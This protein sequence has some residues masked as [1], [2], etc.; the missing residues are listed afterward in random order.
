MSHT[1]EEKQLMRSVERGEW[2]PVEDLE[3]EIR[4]S[5]EIARATTRKDQRMNIRI[6]K[7]DLE[8]L[9]VRALEEGMPYQTLVATVIR[10]YLS[11][12]LVERR[13]IS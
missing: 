8:D 4:R 6:S 1:R 7:K 11:G 3:N 12:K 13:R 2:S 5:R 9:K 10:K